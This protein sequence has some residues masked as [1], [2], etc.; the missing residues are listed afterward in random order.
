MTVQGDVGPT[1]SGVASEEVGHVESQWPRAVPRALGSAPRRIAFGPLEIDLSHFAAYC[2]AR[3][4]PLTRMEFDLLTYLV[5]HPDRV[6]STE[7]L[8]REVAHTCLRPESSLIR[9]HVSHL[10]RKLGHHARVIAT[11]RGR[12][13]QL[14]ESPWEATR[15]QC[16]GAAEPEPSAPSPPG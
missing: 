10:R 12:G 8:A 11:V 14:V 7:E 15:P 6:V 9:V 5:R 2:S 13:L 3:L 4:L 1:I 16:G